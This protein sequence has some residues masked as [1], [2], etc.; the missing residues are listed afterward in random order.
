MR[1]Y[2]R[3]ATAAV[4]HHENMALSVFAHA[5]STPDLVVFRR[6][7]PTG[8]VDVTAA[9]FAAL[10]TGVAKGL[11]VAGVTPGDRVALMSSTRFEWSLLDFAIL[12]CGGVSVP[13]NH[14]ASPEHVQW[15]LEDSGAVVAI[16]ETDENA[17]RC[18][19]QRPRTDLRVLTIDADAV[20]TLIAEGGAI[21]D[22]EMFRRVVELTADDLASLMY[23]SGTTGRA[24]GCVLSHRNLLA[25]T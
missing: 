12:A 10:V 1:V 3:S 19:S 8:W 18:L 7:E 15:V 14:L 22:S 9:D 13:I 17:A 24:K 20:G 16:V 5:E 21:P 11:I 2:A 4:A 25:Q 23:T 6:A